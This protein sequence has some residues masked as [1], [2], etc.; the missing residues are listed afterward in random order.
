[1]RM[2]TAGLAGAAI[3]VVAATVFAVTALMQA[4][5]A[6]DGNARGGFADI[7]GPFTLTDKTG[8]TVTEADFK[9]KPSAI[10]FGFTFCPDVCPTTL[11]ELSGAME[12]LG[13]DAD[14]MNVVFV[15]V[16]WE[17]DGP[18]ELERYVSAF[19]DRIRGLSGTKDEIER[20]TR[21]YRVYYKRVPTEDG[22]DYTIDHSALVYLMDSD[23]RFFGTISYN[24]SPEMMLGKLK[25]LIAEG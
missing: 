17:R 2:K 22:E 24:E 10:F 12:E 11:Y 15:S 19:D 4:P 21:A 13:A 25:R 8:R 1:M 3:L 7:G 9:G 20:I 14:R 16:D 5:P 6:G 23:G 18:E